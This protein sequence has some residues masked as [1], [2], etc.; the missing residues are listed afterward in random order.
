[1]YSILFVVVLISSVASNDVCHLGD[2]RSAT[3]RGHCS[4]GGCAVV[5]FRDNVPQ[6]RCL[7]D[8]HRHHPAFVT[9]ACEHSTVDA[10]C[11]NRNSFDPLPSNLRRLG[12]IEETFG[13]VMTS[14][15]IENF[16]CCRG[17]LC[18]AANEKIRRHFDQLP[19]IV[20]ESQR[21]SI[22]N[23]VPFFGI[24]FLLAAFQMFH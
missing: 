17:E 3:T 21:S 19:E 18:N 23:V 7:K 12:L 13:Q 10:T 9:L 16:C 5:S 20:D 4:G 15:G 11:Y 6:Y 8:L 24:T 2:G 14:S 22:S 1:M